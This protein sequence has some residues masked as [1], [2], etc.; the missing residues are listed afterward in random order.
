MAA[1]L[2]HAATLGTHKLSVSSVKF[3]PSGEL[4]ASAGSDCSVRIWRMETEQLESEIQLRSA[5]LLSFW[6]LSFDLF[7]HL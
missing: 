2:E 6:F 7:F 5:G 4:I 1:L 3:S